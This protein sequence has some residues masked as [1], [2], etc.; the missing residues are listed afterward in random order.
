[1]SNALT[2]FSLVGI[3][4]IAPEPGF[5]CVVVRLRIMN[6]SDHKEDGTPRPYEGKRSQERLYF[7]VADREV[8]QLFPRLQNGASSAHCGRI[9]PYVSGGVA[10][11]T[12][13]G[14]GSVDIALT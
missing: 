13:R 6:D 9:S 12:G 10:V 14:D 7:Q 8:S 11:G 4:L 2:V 1:M 5:S 3:R